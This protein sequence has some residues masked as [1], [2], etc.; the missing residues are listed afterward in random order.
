[1]AGV[2]FRCSL[3]PYAFLL[4]PKSSYFLFDGFSPR[5]FTSECGELYWNWNGVFLPPRFVCKRKG[6][7]RN[8]NIERSGSR[9]KFSTLLL[10]PRISLFGPGI[11]SP[12]LPSVPPS[13]CRRQKE[14]THSAARRVGRPVCRLSASPPPRRAL[15]GVGGEI[16]IETLAGNLPSRR[17][18]PASLIE[19]RSKIS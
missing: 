16:P 8:A 5:V 6:S 13:F 19:P 18:V 3:I 10:L 9:G 17:A 14:G 4:P 2:V 7:A 11:A 12:V 15:L 1:M